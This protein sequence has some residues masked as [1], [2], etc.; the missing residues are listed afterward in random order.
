MEASPLTQQTRPET[1]KPKIVQLYEDL[2]QV[3]RSILLDS[4]VNADSSKTS[5]YTDPTEGFWREF[6]LLAPDPGKLSS[7]LDE[8]SPDDILNLQ[9]C[10]VTMVSRCR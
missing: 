8:L 3:G 10:S 1:F 4:T 6:F 2:F 7:I 5:D 9:V